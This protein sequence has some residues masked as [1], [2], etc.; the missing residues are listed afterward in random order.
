MALDTWWDL[1]S[2]TKAVSTTSCVLSLLDD[3]RLELDQ[4]IASYLP[5]DELGQP[6][7]TIR[8]FLT[9]S[10]GLPPHRRLY[11]ECPDRQAFRTELLRTSPASQA[12]S[13]CVYS[14]VG[15]LTLGFAV[16]ALT[17]QRQDD[18]LRERVLQPL[19]LSEQLAYGPPVPPDRCA[20]TEVCAYRG[21]LVRA[22]V[23]DE[24]AWRCDGVAGHAGLF[25]TVEGVGRFGQEML[26]HAVFSRAVY[27]ELFTVRD[28]VASDRFW[29]GWKRLRYDT[30]D[31]P[32]FGHD[33]FT[34]TLLWCSPSARL[35][36]ALLTNRVHPTRANRRLYDFRP[37]W[38]HAAW[39]LASGG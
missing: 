8:Q 16:E 10:T 31:D 25:G 20:A 9:H 17:G 26:D 18:F 28:D 7:A 39:E 34:G 15:F 30:P 5:D 23:H 36:I 11:A 1:A 12:G 35:V 13:D 14:D 38:I 33:G 24:N 22:E 4:A 29:L 6:T 3:G 27:D 21:R 2:V 37:K 19:G 32:A